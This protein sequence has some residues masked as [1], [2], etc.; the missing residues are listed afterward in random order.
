MDL[1]ISKWIF[2]TFHT[3]KAF[4]IFWALMS[5]LGNLWAFVA[6]TILLLCFKKTRKI[7]LFMAVSCGVVW[8]LNSWILKPLI[9]RPR[10]FVSTPEL[11]GLCELAGMRLPPAFSMASGHAANSMAIAMTI[12]MF[13]KKWGGISFIYP[14]MIGLSRV[15]LCVHYFSDVVTGWIIGALV[16]IACHYLLNL[17]IKYYV[18]K[19][20]KKNG[21]I[22]SSVSE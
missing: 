13:S 14:F 8:V 10:P 12:F 20:E 2:N 15:C 22:S 1:A 18:S 4:A 7:G 9:A 6:I 11:A 16:A 19:K 3:N 5:F 17:L 21:K